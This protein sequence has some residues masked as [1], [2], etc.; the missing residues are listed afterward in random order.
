MRSAD[1][2]AF[3]RTS[4]VFLLLAAMPASA[5]AQSWP[6]RL[7]KFVVTL[8]PGSGVDFGAR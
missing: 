5:A 6:Q 3:L 1:L 4:L 7:V 2:L 8:G